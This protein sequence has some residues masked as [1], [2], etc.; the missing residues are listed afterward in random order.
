MMTALKSRNM[1]GPDAPQNGPESLVKIVNF[2][3]DG[4]LQLVHG[5]DR[6]GFRITGTRHDGAVI[7]LPRKTS[8]WNPPATPMEVK[9]TDILPFLGTPPPPL[10]I[11]GAGDAPQAPLAALGTALRESGVNLEVMSTPAACRTW[12]VLMSEGRNAAA[13][14]YLVR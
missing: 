2:D 7:L 12:N 9:S 1:N 13:C 6:G 8:H 4:A 5:Y 14:L 10:L 11:I 3:G